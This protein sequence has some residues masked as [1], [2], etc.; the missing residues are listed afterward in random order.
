MIGEY[1]PF[2]GELFR[3]CFYLGYYRYRFKPFEA[4]PVTTA[5]FL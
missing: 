1:S 2:A 4:L 5:T 3:F